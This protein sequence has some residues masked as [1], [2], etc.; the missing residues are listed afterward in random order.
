MS[1]RILEIEILR[2]LALPEFQDLQA[3]GII[4]SPINLPRMD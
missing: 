2:E 4:H 3:Q 1:P